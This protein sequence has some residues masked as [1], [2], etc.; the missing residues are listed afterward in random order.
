MPKRPDPD[1]R[2]SRIKA[3]FYDDNMDVDEIASLFEVTP[4]SVNFIL[5]RHENIEANRAYERKLRTKRYAKDDNF[6]AAHIERVKRSQAKAAATE[7][8]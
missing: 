2:T 6:R 4:R 8:A 3:A 1:S 7:D 5:W